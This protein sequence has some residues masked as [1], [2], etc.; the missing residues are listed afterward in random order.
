VIG[1]LELVRRI[2]PTLTVY[3]LQARGLDDDRALPATIEQMARDYIAALR[4]VQPH[5]PYRLAGWSFGGVVAYAMAHALRAAGETVER[6]VMIDAIA[7]ALAG[8]DIAS[9]DAAQLL[10]G[11]AREIG[12]EGDL[13][14]GIAERSDEAAMAALG[15][16]AERE[17][18]LDAG[19]DLQRLTRLYRVHRHNAQILWKYLPPRSDS[20]LQL[21]T[22]A[23]ELARIGPARGW[24]RVVPAAQIHVIDMQATHY[25]ILRAPHVQ[26]IAEHLNERVAGR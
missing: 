1:Y 15:K 23:G 21:F 24:D 8:I 14:W 12:Y 9:A 19:T 3:G 25:G 10:R 6:L 4:R 2:D 16:A 7:P 13:D 20:A 18:L 11:F 5:G 26:R 17:G 22:A